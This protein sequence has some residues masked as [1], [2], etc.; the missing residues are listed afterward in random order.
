M[1]YQRKKSNIIDRKMFDLI[2]YKTLKIKRKIR[3]NKRE[4]IE[5]KKQFIQYFLRN[6]ILY[7]N[8]KRLASNFR[9]LV[10]D[11]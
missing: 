7:D 2:Q 6:F 1:Q 9:E 11:F 10:N 8:Q 3:I 4:K 5:E